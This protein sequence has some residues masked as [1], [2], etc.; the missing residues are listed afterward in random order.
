MLDYKNTQLVKYT[1]CK[2][3]L[4]GRIDK[5]EMKIIRYYQEDNRFITQLINDILQMILFKTRDVNLI[6]QM[7]WLRMSINRQFIKFWSKRE[8]GFIRNIYSLSNIQKIINQD[9]FRDYNDQKQI[10]KY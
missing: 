9:Y 1:S 4:R 2:K 5:I 8:A 7:V 6:N 3:L 10:A